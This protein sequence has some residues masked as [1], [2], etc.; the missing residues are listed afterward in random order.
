[1]MRP[2]AVGIVSALLIAPSVAQAQ[3]ANPHISDLTGFIETAEEFIH[4]VPEG[5][6]SGQE[7]YFVPDGKLSRAEYVLFH[8]VMA[9][10]DLNRKFPY[11]MSRD[12]KLTLAQN[13]AGQA[14]DMLDTNRDGYMDHADD[15]NRD[16]AITA[17][18]RR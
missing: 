1:M 14:F 11:S 4:P 13:E 15:T 9:M 18:D 17:A 3:E 7:D 8:G 2:L 10:N 6:F 5:L 12:V 16:N